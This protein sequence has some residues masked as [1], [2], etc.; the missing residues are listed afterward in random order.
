M[1]RASQLSVPESEPPA[2]AKPAYDPNNLDPLDEEDRRNDPDDGI[3][4]DEIIATTQDDWLA[5]NYKEF[6]PNDYPDEESFIK[7]LEAY[8]AECRTAAKR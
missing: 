1:N 6:D 2:R 8:H 4:Y 5:G 7:A 3:D